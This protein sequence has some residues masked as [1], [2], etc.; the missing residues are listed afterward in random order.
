M[1]VL[2]DL[3]PNE[4]H[5]GAADKASHKHVLRILIDLLGAP[6]LLRKAVFHDNDPVAH[7][8]GLGLV[9]GHVD[10]G[11]GQPRVKLFDL[12]PHLH[13]EFS[14]QVGEGLIHK[15]DQGVSHDSPS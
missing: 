5:G 11:G 10:K 13:P 4:V 15:K 9:V 14:I 3:G 2:G 1:T 12:H 6:H 8:H 7:G